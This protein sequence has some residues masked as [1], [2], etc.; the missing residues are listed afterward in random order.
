MRQRSLSAVLTC[1]TATA[2]LLPAA[3]V[4]ASSSP[5]PFTDE[6]SNGSITLC[7]RDGRPVTSGSLITQPFVWKAV[8]SSPAPAGYGRAYLTLYQPLQHEDASD[9][10]GYQMTD[11]SS[12][13][14]PTH[15]AAQSTNL[16]APLLDPDRQLPP[17]WEGLYEL[18]MYFTSPLKAPFTT[19]YPTAVIKVTGNNWSL[20]SGGG[21]DC[22]AGQAVSLA[23]RTAAQA[24]PQT[25]RVGPPTTSAS[26][27]GTS[28]GRTPVTASRGPSSTPSTG[29]ASPAG[30]EAVASRS[31]SGPL[32]KPA[33]GGSW[34]GP[35]A[36][37]GIGA[38]LIL[39]GAVFLQR[40]RR[41]TAG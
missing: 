3:P 25:I 30:Q 9:W 1:V 41:H 23:S 4:S 10:T 12:F 14:P 34:A 24:T 39:G 5:V 7:G 6:Y 8:S 29:P 38:A 15:P 22:S 27:A 26:G 36:A 35:I 17:Y 13:T 37:I 40:R 11:V 33:S 19:A 16:D 18:R 21:V 20:V 32:G 31:A 2:V 28:T